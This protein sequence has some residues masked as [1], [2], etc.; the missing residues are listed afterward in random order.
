[1]CGKDLKVLA[2]QFLNEADGV[3]LYG[4]VSIKDLSWIQLIHQRSHIKINL[5]T[6]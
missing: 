3:I 4:Q 5:L 2:H 1:M 6:H